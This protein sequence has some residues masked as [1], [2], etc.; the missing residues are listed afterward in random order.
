MVKIRITPPDLFLVLIVFE[1]ILHFIFPIKNLII[2]PYNYLGILLF[3]IG[4][5]PNLWIGIYFRK[6]K[7]S[8]DINEKPKKFVTS[9]LFRLSRNPI[10]LGMVLA[11]I[12]L[13]IFL[14][15]IGPFLIPILFIILTNSF[16]IPIEERNLEK[17]FGK[18]YLKY[19]SQVRRWI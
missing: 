15:S 9:G 1:I 12:G 18:K 19:K 4:I 17:Q 3:I 8:I 13:G 14:G 2:P 5:L 16:V 10:Y 6:I 11:L 7:T